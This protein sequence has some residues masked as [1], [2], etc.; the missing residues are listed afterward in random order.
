MPIADALFSSE[1]SDWE[2]PEWLFKQLDEEFDFG[3]DAA[4]NSL[5]AKCDLYIGEQRN[6]LTADWSGLGTV[7]LNPPYGRH[8]G[9]WIE[10][11]YRESQKGIT[12]VV[13]VPARTDTAW[14]HDWAMRAQEIRFIRGRLKFVGAAS[15]APFPSA[16][17]IF[18]QAPKFTS[19]GRGQTCKK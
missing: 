7:W 19:Y 1:K 12:V 8:I 15:S 17:L 9:Q 5:N 16:I 6:A 2:T 13:L 14:W 3:L 11:A 18:K 10:K 4:A